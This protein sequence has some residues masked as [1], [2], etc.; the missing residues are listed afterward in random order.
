MEVRK[1]YQNKISHRIAALEN[2][3]H[4]E[5]IGLGRTLQ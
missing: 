5:D 3:S 1:Q 2:L 4:S